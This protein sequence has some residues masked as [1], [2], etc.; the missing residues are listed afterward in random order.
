MIAES[1]NISSGQI[2][3]M[4]INGLTIDGNGHTITIKDIESAGNGGYLFYD[5][6]KLNVKD[7]TIEIADG[8]VGGICLKSGTIS[9]VTFKGGQYGVLP[10]NGGVTVEGCTFD[11][12]KGYAVY[13]ETARENIATSPLA[14]APCSLVPHRERRLSR[15]SL[16]G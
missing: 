3:T 11:G 9:N 6:T 15:F 2:V 5:A 12:T 10:G 8:L 16:S 7:L 4:A 14:T 1:L 13:Y